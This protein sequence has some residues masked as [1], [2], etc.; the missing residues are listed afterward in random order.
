MAD[1]IEIASLIGELR[2]RL[3]LSQ[4]KLAAQLKVS[5]PTINRWQKGRAKPDPRAIHLIR[6]FL[7]RLGPEYE[8]LYQRYFSGTAQAVLF[9]QD[10]PSLQTNRTKRR[11][12]PRVSGT[13]SAVKNEISLDT[14]SM[15]GLLWKAAC[16]IRG[17]KDAPKFKDYILPLV[18]IKRLSDVFEDEIVRLTETYDD[19]ETARTV[20]GS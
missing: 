1:D 3:G 18:F 20:S 8:D 12:T 11:E 7:Q 10:F 16:S 15:E 17:E 14:K 4:E 2:D 6:Q 13:D 9:E 5:L 19:E